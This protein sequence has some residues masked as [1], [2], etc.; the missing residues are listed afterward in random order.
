M[1]QSTLPS[2]AKFLDAL[3]TLSHELH[4]TMSEDELVKMFASVFE[5]LLPDRLFSIRT[6]KKD[7]GLNL[8]YANGRLKSEGRDS[9]QVTPRAFAGF[10]INK[11]QE[12][13]ILRQGKVAQVET[14]VPLF[15]NG[16]SGF[17][18]ILCDRT[19]F[20][21]MI[22]LEYEKNVSHLDEDYR[23]ALPLV[24]HLVA[25]LRNARLMTE[26]VRLNEYME[27]L[28]DS[29]NAPVVVV[30]REGKITVANKAF[31]ERI[32][33][34]RSQLVGEEFMSFVPADNRGRLIPYMISAIKGEPSTNIEMRFPKGDSLDT[35][36]I[37]FNTS[38]LRSSFGEIE[39]VI[40]VG[41]DL[42][43]IR[44]LQKQ[45]IHTEKLATLGQ[46]AA[47]VAHELNNPLTSITIYTNYLLNKLDG[48]IT[49][50]DYSK[51]ARILTGANRIQ[52]FTRDL[53]NYARPS[54]DKPDL[55][56]VA[57]LV[58]RSVSFCEHVIADSGADVAVSV[59][60]S[61]TEI[62]GI[63]GQMEQVFVNLITN[64]CHSLPAS[65]GMIQI[66]ASWY[67]TDH[68]QISVE[69]S[70]GGIADTHLKKVFEPFFTT[71][72]VGQGTGL[73][74]SIVK[75]ILKNHDAE[76]QVKSKLGQGTR[77][78]IRMRA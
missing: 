49:D 23:I 31:E 60:D 40:F 74:L 18:M 33:L 59:D 26:T 70:G 7:S 48:E 17:E 62:Y 64:A 56:S 47:G 72:D 71:K 20:Y 38:P 5:E 69:D 46:L 73:G 21:G 51:L 25:A 75:N 28:F 52:S 12:E 68:I 53:V 2:D 29:A 34:L 13:E 4:V 66:A 78:V 11:L 14:Y 58:E 24:H 50:S 77:F 19:K 1:T 10:K 32:G 57:G 43:E 67:G 9:F 44:D 65:G 22:N 76:I 16:V 35:A 54:E 6:V 39:G 55:L 15:E 37:A 30:D 36:H 8:V 61:L 3:L 27:K 41:Q 45:I 42:T 63:R